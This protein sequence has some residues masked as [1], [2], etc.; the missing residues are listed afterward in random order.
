MTKNIY[1]YIIFSFL[2]TICLIL[3]DYFIKLFK[4][5]GLLFHFDTFVYAFILSLSL[6]LIK[7]IKVFYTVSI[8][9]LLLIF[10]GCFYYLF[11]GRYF[12]GFDIL[13][14]FYE[15]EDI[16][17]GFISS[18]FS[19]WY[20]I[21]SIIISFLGI[22]YIRKFS[23]NL[24]KSNYCILLVFVILSIIPYRIYKVGSSYSLP[25]SIHYMYYNSLKSFFSFFI[26]VLPRNNKQIKQFQP[27]EIT[28]VKD[29]TDK[30]TIIFI[31]GESWNPDHFSLFGYQRK[32]TP[33]L[34]TMV[35]DKNFY[36]N[37]ALSYSVATRI[38][39]AGFFNLQKEPENFLLQQSK[40]NNIFKFAKQQGFYTTFL[41][42]QSLT[43]FPNIGIEYIDNISYK[44][45]SRLKIKEYGDWYSIEKLK[46]LQLT[47]K[48]FIA[49]QTRLVH[50][51]YKKAYAHYLETCDKF[52]DNNIDN[53][54]NEYDNGIFCLDMF[55][56]DIFTFA[57]N[58][59]GK[60]YV[61]M[62]SDHGEL[63]GENNIWGHCFLD[64]LVAN[65]PFI[66][67]SKNVPSK[68]FDY[69]KSLSI[70]SHYDIGKFILS[71]LGY[72]VI[73]P[74]SNE[75]ILYINGM[76]LMGMEGYKVFKR[77]IYGITEINQK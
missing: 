24:Y 38:S 20:V 23:K 46:N 28:K 12:V 9:I 8:I 57:N 61:I 69:I 40:E 22:Y 43:A 39:N 55:L 64:R 49:I 71:I 27:Y 35:K 48:N 52:K 34:D 1:K 53:R 73:N 6:L 47:D 16:F 44:D 26:D 63:F 2:F 42:A 5:Y 60:V 74:N 32:T 29:I 51:P 66:L 30:T 36:F 10:S 25:N 4:D 77:D 58:L 62:V 59:D 54:I 11:F 17:T 18:I 31:M 19:Y 68:E 37:K 50:S 13:M 65:I 45:K 21:I 14:L 3:P 41:S 33:N 15:T 56:K 70:Q 76:D 75:D 72:S 67:W 7:N